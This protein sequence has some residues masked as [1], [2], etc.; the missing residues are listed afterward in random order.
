MALLGTSSRFEQLRE[1]L[2]ARRADGEP[3]QHAWA[4]LTA[5]YPDAD[6]LADTRPAWE[7]AYDREPATRGD[8]AVCRL[9]ALTERAGVDA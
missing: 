3:F 9:S 1:A 2:A 5:G 6:V 4:A 8:E 7:R